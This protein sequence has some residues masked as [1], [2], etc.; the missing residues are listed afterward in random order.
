M[1]GTNFFGTDQLCWK[2]L[3]QWTSSC[4]LFLARAALIPAKLRIK[5]L[6]LRKKPAW[7]GL[8]NIQKAF[9]RSDCKFQIGAIRIF[10]SEKETRLKTLSRPQTERERETSRLFLAEDCEEMNIYLGTFCLR[11]AVVRKH[12]IVKSLIY[13][14]ERRGELRRLIWSR[15]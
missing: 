10:T 7:R 12:W 11:R 3:P 15:N 5:T 8:L 13:W 1:Y 6:L 4:L 9:K 14:S 2:S